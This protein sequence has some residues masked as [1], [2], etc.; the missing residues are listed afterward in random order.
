MTGAFHGKQLLL[1]AVPI[2]GSEKGKTDQGSDAHEGID[3]PA[4]DGRL[5]AENPCHNVELKNRR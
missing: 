3:D 2:V 1:A 5:T 4:D